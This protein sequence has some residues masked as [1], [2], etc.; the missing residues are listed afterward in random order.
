[1]NINSELSADDFNNY[2]ITACDTQTTNSAH[3][4]KS[5]QVEQPQSMFLA[6]VTDDEILKTIARKMQNKKSVG[7]DD[8][9]VRILKKAAKIVSPY[10]K[11]GSQ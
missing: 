10:I 8:M 2:F 3:Q 11:K 9:D 4:W 7:I 6:P 5:H 1:M